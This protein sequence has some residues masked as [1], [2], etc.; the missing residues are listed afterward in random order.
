MI[1][2][3]GAGWVSVGGARMRWEGLAPGGWGRSG[4][5]WD[6]NAGW[7]LGGRGW[8]GEVGAALTWRCRDLSVVLNFK[9]PGG[10][11]SSA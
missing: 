10:C 7:R 3:A 9:D 8:Q 2:D 4:R 1:C 6:Q 11:M 5:G